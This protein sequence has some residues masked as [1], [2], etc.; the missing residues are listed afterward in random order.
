LRSGG[1]VVPPRTPTRRPRSAESVDATPEEFR[2]VPDRREVDE[3]VEAVA[4]TN[5][6]DPERCPFCGT[7]LA[8]GGTG[9]IDHIESTPD[10]DRRFE[11][12]REAISGDL[13]GEWGG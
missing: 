1:S 2:D 6:D 3:E 9:F 13:G 10:C 7:V 8:D 4:D 5:W 11:E 12:W